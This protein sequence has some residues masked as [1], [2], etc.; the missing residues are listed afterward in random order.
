MKCQ[1]ANSHFCKGKFSSSSAKQNGAGSAGAGP[2]LAA[3][4]EDAARFPDS[5][6]GKGRQEIPGK[7]AQPEA[8]RAGSGALQRK[9]RWSSG[10]DRGAKERWG[11]LLLRGRLGLSPRRGDGRG[12][13][14]S[15][16]VGTG[17][18]ALRC[19]PGARST[20][21]ATTAKGQAS[22]RRRRALPESR[23]KGWLNPM[24]AR[25]NKRGQVRFCRSFRGRPGGRS[26]DSSPRK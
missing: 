26:A 5:H 10:L 4:K 2:L 13:P 23:R 15:L 11:A 17:P 25:E 3:R 1:S 9:R 22:P 8:E 16:R 7:G 12:R 24:S 14:R 19:R 6:A 21:A 20:R 18:P